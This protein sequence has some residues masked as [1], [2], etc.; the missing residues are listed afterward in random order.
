MVHLLEG[1]PIEFNLREILVKNQIRYDDKDVQ[2]YN[3]ILSQLLSLAKPKCLYKECY[4]HSRGKDFLKIDHVLFHSRVLQANLETV[5]R[6]FAF[7]CTVGREVDDYSY[8]GGL[9]NFTHWIEIVKFEILVMAYHYLQT[10]IKDHY[11][12]SDLSAMQP[13]AGDKI[14]W[15]IEQQK[16]LFF[17]F[18]DWPQKIGVELLSNFFMKPTHT[19][20]GFLF[21]TEQDYQSCQLCQKNPCSLRR[22]DFNQ[23]LWEKLLGD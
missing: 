4:I 21:P 10:Y 23:E 17:L 20:S 16:D 8:Q 14:L 11:R 1:I 7:I 9:R 13:G 5:E 19:I 12:L 3:S 22:A 15:P 2:N 6:V 18:E